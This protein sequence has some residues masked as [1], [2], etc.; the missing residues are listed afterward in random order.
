MNRL[1]PFP[2]AGMRS[3]IRFGNFMLTVTVLVIRKGIISHL[4]QCQN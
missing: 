1:R 2:G 3:A 4:K